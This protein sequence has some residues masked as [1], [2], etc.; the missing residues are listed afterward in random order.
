MIIVPG[1]DVLEIE[2]WVQNKDIGFVD[3]GQTVEI[4]VEAFPFTKYGTIDGELLT[5]SNDAVELDNIGYV[6]AARVSM[7]KSVI[8]VGTKLVNLTPG[9]TVT[10]EIKT[11][12]RRVI[13]FLLTPLL[14]GIDEAAR[15]R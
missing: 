4:K 7:V 14:R 5:L 8:D 15:E 11:G 12:K 3:E 6:F 2:A 9:M 10:I 13:E 1:E